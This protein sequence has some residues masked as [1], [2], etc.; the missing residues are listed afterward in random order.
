M[1]TLPLLAK[2]NLLSAM[3]GRVIYRHS[4]TPPGRSSF[5]RW[6]ARLVHLQAIPAC[7]EN[8]GAA[9]GLLAYQVV[10][11]ALLGSHWHCL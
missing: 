1:T 3:A 2:D 11:F 5:L 7:S 10:A 6:P 9:F 4:G 8:L